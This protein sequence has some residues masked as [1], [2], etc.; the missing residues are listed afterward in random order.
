[1]RLTQSMRRVLPI[2]VTGLILCLA[3]QVEAGSSDRAFF[4]EMRS[5][6]ATAYILGS[7]HLMRSDAYPLN[8]SIEEA[9]QS[10]KTLVVEINDAGDDDALTRIMRENISGPEAVGLRAALSPETYE[11]ARKKLSQYGLDIAALETLPPWVLATMLTVLETQRHGLDPE[12]GVDR[13]FL[14]KAR[15]S[16]KRILPLE[17]VE[18]QLSLLNSLSM[19]EQDALLVSTLEELDELGGQ[20]DRIMTA[21]KSGDESEIEAV[22]K[23]GMKEQPFGGDLYR[24]IIYD[25]NVNMASR[26]DEL[27]QTDGTAFV[28][29]GAAHLVGEDGIISLLQRRGHAAERR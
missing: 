6:K 15:G 17:S 19:H 14:R 7:I 23:E 12:H 24:K 21:W 4:W 2:V 28:V 8:P 25:R 16:S 20:I 29:V 5:P 9:F 1:M 13:Y 3:C 11:R 26:I 27:L 18:Y 10:A 22:I